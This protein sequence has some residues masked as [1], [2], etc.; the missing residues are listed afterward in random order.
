MRGL[1]DT[2]REIVRLLLADSRRPFSDI[3]EEVGLS[4]PAVSDRVDRLREMGVVRGFTLDLDRSLLRSGVPV[5]L[6][7]DAEPGRATAVRD[8]LAGA[9]AVEHVFRT[10][11]GRVTATATVPQTEVT[12]LLDT[13]VD[14]ADV[15]GYEVRLVADS[16]W[17]PGLGTAEF[18][19]ECAECGNTVDEEGERTV[20]DGDT[21]YFCC[22]SCESR[23]V[24]R[25]ESL[26]EGA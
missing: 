11:D 4:A 8:A 18:A 20:L 21:Y 22:G 9:D 1:D 3:A 10:A 26:K 14:L 17:S 16:E 13:H 2:D 12:E 19:P 15:D 6:E 25:Y 5:L 7:I 23:F 24:E